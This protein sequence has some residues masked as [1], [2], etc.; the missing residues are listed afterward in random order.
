MCVNTARVCSSHQSQFHGDRAAEEPITC[1]LPVISKSRGLL[2]DFPETERKK[3]S[4]ERNSIRSDH[5]RSVSPDCG[6]L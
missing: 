6:D 5:E 3:K 1:V 2:P 4:D